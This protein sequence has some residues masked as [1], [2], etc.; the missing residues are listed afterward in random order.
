M[1]AVGAEAWQGARTKGAGGKVVL[2]GAAR[3]IAKAGGGGGASEDADGPKKSFAAQKKGK[4]PSVALRKAKKLGIKVRDFPCCISFRFSLAVPGCV[5]CG[6]GLYKILQIL[7]SHIL[8]CTSSRVPC[9]GVFC[10]WW[11]F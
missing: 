2:G 8:S 11:C 9:W 4:R 3:R 10:R 5:S 7:H 1:K 6:C